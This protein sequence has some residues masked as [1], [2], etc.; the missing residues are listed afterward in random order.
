MDVKERHAETKKI[1]AEIWAIYV[2]RLNTMQ[3]ELP[4]TW[5]DDTVGLFNVEVKKYRGGS[6]EKYV[7]KYV[8]ACLDDLEEIC[9]E[10]QKY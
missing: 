2:N 10:I 9:K 3:G 6:H 5:W 4:D 7:T 1:S 8:M